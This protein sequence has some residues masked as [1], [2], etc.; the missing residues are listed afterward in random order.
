MES[1]KLNRADVDGWIVRQID[2]GKVVHNAPRPLLGEP[3]PGTYAGA[4]GAIH[5]VFGSH[6]CIFVALDPSDPYFQRFAANNERMDARAI[7]LTDDETEH[8]AFR[9]ACVENDADYNDVCADFG[10]WARAARTLGLVPSE[11]AIG[12]R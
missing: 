11:A 9:V 5:G 6:G 8:D 3:A 4:M 2:A 12:A 1:I 10:G 7:V